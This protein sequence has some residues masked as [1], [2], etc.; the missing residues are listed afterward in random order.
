MIDGIIIPQ[1]NGW[2]DDPEQVEAIAVEQEFQSFADTPAGMVSLGELPK[3]V[4]MWKIHHAVTGLNPDDENQGNYGS[5]VG[6]GTVAGVEATMVYQIFTGASEEWKELSQEIVYGGS[7]IEI[8]KGRLGRGQGSI[9]AWAAQFVKKYGV[10]PRGVYGKYDLTKYSI[11]LCNQF[12]INGVPDELESA[13]KEHPVNDIVQ[14]K[15]W[16]DAKKALAQGMGIS[17]C[18]NQGFTMKRDA[19]GRCQPSGKWNHCMALW[20]YNTDGDEMGWIKNSW[21]GN[22]TSGPRGAGEPPLCGFWADASVIDSMLRQNDSWA[23]GNAKGFPKQ[24]V[25]V[26]DWSSL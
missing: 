8:G 23:F 12:G 6:F 16:E 26:I 5:C 13:T 7:R 11:P 21:G 15:S 17:V 20:G 10:L 25:N 1:F 18:S 19:K 24:N 9:G 2:V 22:A 14:V 3:E 4:F